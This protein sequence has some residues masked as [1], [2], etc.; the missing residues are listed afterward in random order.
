MRKIRVFEA[1]AALAAM[2]GGVLVAAPAVGEPAVSKT[3]AKRVVVMDNFFEPRYIEIHKGERVVWVWKGDNSHNVTFIKVPKAASKNGA[4]TR[5]EGRWSRRFRKRGFYK[6]ICT[7]HSGQRGSIE[8]KRAE[9]PPTS[10][11]R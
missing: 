8:V 10:L 4:D 9:P 11:L 3:F 6:Y 1:A 2:L 7:I 5:R